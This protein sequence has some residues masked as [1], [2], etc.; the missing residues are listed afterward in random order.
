MSECPKCDIELQS[1]LTACPTCGHK[2]HEVHAE[3]KNQNQQLLLALGILLV[4]FLF[5][6]FYLVDF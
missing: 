5:L 4:V 2:L 6:T 3:K 1:G